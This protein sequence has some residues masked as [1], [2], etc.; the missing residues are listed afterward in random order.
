M[1][2]NEAPWWTKLEGLP[3][4]MKALAQAREC[5]GH[6]ASCVSAQEAVLAETQEYQFLQAY[7]KTLA[8]ARDHVAALDAAVRAEALKDF[9]TNG[10]KA[11]Y[12]GVSVKLFTKIDYD[13]KAMRD[14]AK[15]NMT[16]LLTLDTKATEMAAKAGILDDAPVTV[17]KEARAIIAS[18]LAFYLQADTPALDK[19]NAE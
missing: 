8:D 17:T 11:V 7:K 16:S 6:A 12:V 14:W 18:D 10:E 9:K 3:S 13:P 15:A 4:M 19:S 5:A 1:T 2:E